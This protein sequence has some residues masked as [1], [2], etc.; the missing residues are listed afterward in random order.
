MSST[1]SLGGKEGVD[2]GI[3]EMVRNPNQPRIL[4]SS[5]RIQKF[6]GAPMQKHSISIE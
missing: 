6:V 3:Y 4:G 5:D 2:N 1:E